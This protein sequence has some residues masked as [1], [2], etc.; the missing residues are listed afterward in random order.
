MNG[1]KSVNDTRNMMVATSVTMP[2]GLLV[3]L[4]NWHF[5]VAGGVGMIIA[6]NYTIDEL[7]P[8]IK[9][10]LKVRRLLLLSR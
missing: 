10:A 4:H 6:Q 5:V 7:L 1:R 9:F 3:F 8:N 2:R